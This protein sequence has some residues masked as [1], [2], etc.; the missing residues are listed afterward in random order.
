MSSTANM[1]RRMPSVF[2]G[3]PCGSDLTAGRDRGASQPRRVAW[4]PVRVGCGRRWRV[5][6][7]Q[8]KPTVAVRGAHHRNL[9]SDVLEPDDK[10]HPTSLDWH[11]AL[12]LH[13]QLDKERLRSL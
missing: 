8:L 7:G 11:L 3:A 4:C 9:A 12:Q 10:V 13:T 2:T 5:K 1:M 6:L